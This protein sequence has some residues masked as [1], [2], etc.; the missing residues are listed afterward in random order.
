L[1]QSWP[2]GE[3]VAPLLHAD[4]IAEIVAEDNIEPGKQYLQK[5]LVERTE[6]RTTGGRNQQL[7]VNIS[8][9][10]ELADFGK[11]P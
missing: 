3:D 10:N 7:V 4:P 5:K 6:A 8:V 1:L 2:L 11:S 9:D